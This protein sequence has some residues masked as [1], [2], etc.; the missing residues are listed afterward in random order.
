M[1][2]LRRQCE[3]HSQDEEPTELAVTESIDFDGAINLQ[4]ARAPGVKVSPERYIADEV[5][6]MA[7]PLAAVSG[8]GTKRTYR[9]VCY[10]SAFEPKRT[11]AGD[12]RAI[13]IL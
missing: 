9:A 4:T 5:I 10:S 11:S 7:G 2:S 8:F 6:D 1:T 13:A 12:W 3:P